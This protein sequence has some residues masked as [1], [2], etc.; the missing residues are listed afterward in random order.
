M[1]KKDLD[2][3]TAE[4]ERAY[5]LGSVTRLRECCVPR[6]IFEIRDLSVSFGQQ[7]VLENVSLDIFDGCI[8]AIVGP[9]G[10]GK[11]TFL[12]ALSRLIALEE[13]Y[14]IKGSIRFAG[15][16]VYL[17]NGK[18]NNALSSFRREVGFIFQKPTAFPVSI[19]KNLSIPLQEIGMKKRLDREEKIVNALEMV[20]LWGE[21]KNR[22]KHSA[23]TLSGGQQQ[24]LCIARALVLEPKV[25]LMDEPCSSLD[26]IS[27]KIIEELIVKLSGERTIVLVTHNIAQAQRVANYLAVFWG[28]ESGNRIVESGEAQRIFSEPQSALTSALLQGAVG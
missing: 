4:T 15:E 21:V 27:A 13:D 10:A 12:L 6:A 3:Q 1:S 26:S 14:R 18:I 11:S 24:R 22:L 23:L 9:S 20:G 25:L 17:R 8:T 5:Q 28:A 19:W 7:L 16:E 2:N